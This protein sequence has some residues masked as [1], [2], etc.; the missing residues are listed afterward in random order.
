[1]LAGAAAG[2]L[3]PAPDINIPQ[4]ADLHRYL[5]KDTSSEE[6]PWKTSRTPPLREIMEELSPQSETEEVVFMKGSQVGGTEVGNNFIGYVIDQ[7]PGPMLLVWPTVT[8]GEDSSVQRLD[9]LIQ[10][11]QVLAAKIGDPTKR[12]SGN[13][14]LRKKFPGGYLFIRGTK[15]EAGLRSMPIRYVIFE[16]PDAY[17]RDVE[18]KGN[19]IDLARK[20]TAT[21]QRRKIYCV[22][23]PLG[24]D[25]IIAELYK[26]S[27][28]RHYHVPCP[29]CGA[30]QWYQWKDFLYEKDAHGKPLPQT[31]KCQCQACGFLTG[32]EYKEWQL[33]NGA[34]VKDNPGHPRA[35]FHLSALYSPPGL[36]YSWQE[37]VQQHLEALQDKAQR[38]TWSNHCLAEVSQADYEQVQADPLLRRCETYPAKGR[39]PAGGLVL[40]CGVD[41]QHDRFEAVVR[42]FGIGYESWLLAWKTIDGGVKVKK[43]NEELADFLRTDWIHES[44]A[45]LELARVFVDSS[46]QTHLVY[47]LVRWLRK[48]GVT[49]VATKGA[50]TTDAELV[51]KT[52]ARGGAPFRLLGQHALKEAIYARLTIAEP[53]AGYY[54]FPKGT[55]PEYFK[56]LTAERLVTK[57]VRGRMQPRFEQVE[58]QPNHV[59]DCEMQLLAAILSMEPNFTRLHEQLNPPR[60]GE[61]SPHQDAAP[62]ASDLSLEELE[63]RLGGQS[64]SGRDSFVNRGRS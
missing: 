41:V 50:S 12:G 53:G 26:N 27:D 19:P 4:W 47:Q 33:A 7:D 22:S 63:R 8:A 43:S 44:G 17:D 58:S 60:E 30:S 28:Q 55:D 59:L 49:A 18:G 3:A 57:W 40:V 16:E 5:T 36:G 42:A 61:K 10:S 38:K 2:A 23:T 14:R 11:S 35:G 64:G 31:V 56:Q 1:M 45:K 39:V 21:F 32:E 20:R 15:R 37:I 54:H 6:G 62:K 52:K 51:A 48:N 24:Q 13:T 46:D 25:S 29:S 9:S 34:W